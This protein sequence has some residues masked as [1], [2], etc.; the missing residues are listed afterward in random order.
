MPYRTEGG[1]E[2]RR[3]GVDADLWNGLDLS[4]EALGDLPNPHR[5]VPTR[6]RQE[7][8]VGGLPTRRQTKKK[9]TE[10]KRDKTAKK[11]QREDKR[12]SFFTRRTAASKTERRANRRRRRHEGRRKRTYTERYI[13]RDRWRLGVRERA[14][15]TLPLFLYA[16]L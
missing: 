13:E 15:E 12:Q 1:G 16:V 14:D 5:V 3:L 4:A 7:T 11:R 6:A 2:E 8:S 9:R 10:T